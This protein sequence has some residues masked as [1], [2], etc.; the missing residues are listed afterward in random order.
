MHISNRT[1]LFYCIVLV[2]GLISINAVAERRERFVNHYPFLSPP[3]TSSRRTSDTRTYDFVAIPPSST[4]K[5]E[6]VTV[7]YTSGETRTFNRFEPDIYSLKSVGSFVRSRSPADIQGCLYGY[8]TQSWY[9]SLDREYEVRRAHTNFF[10]NQKAQDLIAMYWNLI[11]HVKEFVV[12]RS[13]K[14]DEALAKALEES[15]RQMAQYERKLDEIKMDAKLKHR[16]LF[17][18]QERL[19]QW[20]MNKCIRRQYEKALEEIIAM[21]AY[22]NRPHE[23]KRKDPKT[24]E[25][26]SEM[27]S[28][29]LP[30]NPNTGTY[31]DLRFLVSDQLKYAEE[32][33]A[34]NAQRNTVIPGIAT[35]TMGGIANNRE[36]NDLALARASRHSYSQLLEMNNSLPPTK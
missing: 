17:D 1:N 2:T 30:I 14:D 25:I 29:L 27:V 11:A 4:M 20:E 23:Q 13:P 22:Y 35:T 28:H 8:L 34:Y 18:T 6:T 15:R 21:R 24:G 3:T 19:G 26:K 32:V 12:S 7:S 10:H 33:A 9:E 31:F 16:G 5:Q 36:L